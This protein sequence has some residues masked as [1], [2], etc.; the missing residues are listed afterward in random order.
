MPSCSPAPCPFARRRGI[1]RALLQAV[2]EAARRRGGTWVVWQAHPA[3]ADALA[4]YRAVGAHRFR[5][6]DFELTV[7]A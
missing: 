3:N 2:V 1:G 4:F 7:E 6:A 5:A